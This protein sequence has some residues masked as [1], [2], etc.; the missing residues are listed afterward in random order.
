MAVKGKPCFGKAQDEATTSRLIYFKPFAFNCPNFAWK[1]LK[2]P[3]TFWRNQAFMCIILRL[4]DF[5][6][7][8]LFYMFTSL[9]FFP[10]MKSCSNIVSRKCR[11]LQFF[12]KLFLPKVVKN[13]WT[14]EPRFRPKVA[15]L[16]NVICVS[17]WK[18][19]ISLH[20]SMVKRIGASENVYNIKKVRQR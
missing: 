16:Q 14:A 20:N 9:C 3:V 17:L 15:E 8:W 18:K 11:T 4:T 13:A 2:E 10:N 1:S 7:K 5:Q 12:L 6:T 19:W